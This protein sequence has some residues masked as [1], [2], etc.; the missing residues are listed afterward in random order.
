[1]TLR[2]RNTRRLS[3]ITVWRITI[4]MC[5]I[6]RFYRWTII[7][8]SFAF[9]NGLFFLSFDD[10]LQAFSPFFHFFI[11]TKQVYRKDVL[12][13][14]RRAR[15]SEN[16]RS[17]LFSL[18]YTPVSFLSSL[19]MAT[20][21]CCVLKWTWMLAEKSKLFWEEEEEKWPFHPP[22]LTYA[23]WVRKGKDIR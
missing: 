9:P 10:R 8:L 13:R 19:T 23:Q 11:F 16:V 22:R 2:G 1:L 3:L 7:S 12:R 15:R 6:M 5:V 20:V 18:L 21:V 14:D 4:W 17:L